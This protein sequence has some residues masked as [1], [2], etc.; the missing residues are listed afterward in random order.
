MLPLDISWR[1]HQEQSCQCS[2]VCFVQT[3]WTAWIARML[4]KVCLH[5][6]LFKINCRCDNYADP[7]LCGCIFAVIIKSY[8][9]VLQEMLIRNAILIVLVQC[10]VKLAPFSVPPTPTMCVVSP[11]DAIFSSISKM[12]VKTVFMAECVW[13]EKLWLVHTG[14]LI[15]NSIPEYDNM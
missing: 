15:S 12:M 2:R 11:F 1:I 5:T 6:E 4:C 13:I 7:N 8:V 10:I 14:Y 9:K 3:A